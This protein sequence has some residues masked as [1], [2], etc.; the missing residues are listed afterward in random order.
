MP[1][2]VLLTGSERRHQFLRTYIGSVPGIELVLTVSEDQSRNLNAQV[3][4]Q[5]DNLERTKHLREREE[6][7]IAF[8]DA[9]IQSQNNSGALSLIPRGTINSADTTKQVQD[10]EPDFVV[11]FGCSIIR[12]PLID[13][14]SGRF[15]NMH[16]GLSPYYRGS[17]TN[18]WPLVN[19]EPEFIGTTFMH[20]DAGI[21]TGEIIHQVRAKPAFNDSCHSIGNKL[22]VQ[23]ASTLTNL[24]LLNNQ[25]NIQ[26]TDHHFAATPRRIYKKADF[27]EQAVATMRAKMSAG[28]IKSYLSNQ[29]HRIAAAPIYQ[30]PALS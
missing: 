13:S 22:I 25:I 16:L 26:S 27:T 6:S 7:E 1:R 30:H 19:G 14:F 28:L 15:I 9:I 21:D 3:A 4:A 2:V 18:F 29:E 20:I 5:G 17:G 23:S 10:I 11:S 8:F 24:L 12:S